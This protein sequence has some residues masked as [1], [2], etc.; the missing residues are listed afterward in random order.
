M[1]GGQ[2]RSVGC[3]LAVG[4]GQIR[5]GPDHAVCGD[6]PGFFQLVNKKAPELTKELPRAHGGRPHVPLVISSLF[7]AS[8]ERMVSAV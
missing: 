4:A 8:P 2:M 7:V 1:R 3:S 6:R 5:L